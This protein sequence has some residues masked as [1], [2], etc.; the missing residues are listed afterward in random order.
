MSSVRRMFVAAGILSVCM[1][2]QGTP[3]ANADLL[4]PAA[5]YADSG[6]ESAYPATLTIDDVYGPSSPGNNMVVL[7]DSTLPD[8]PI[9]AYIV[10]DLGATCNVTAGTF[11]TRNNPSHM[12]SQP[13]SYQYFYYTDD[14]PANHSVLD[15]I[16]TDPGIVSL[17]NTGPSGSPWLDGGV[18]LTGTF[19]STVTAR[20]VGMRIDSSGPYDYTH[21]DSC[22][23]GEVKFTG[24]IIPEPGALIMC[25]VGLLGILAYAWRKRR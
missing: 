9:T 5:I 3:T 18:S 1:L 14:T 16:G 8:L 23:I 20:Y 7:T 2:W 10:F 13:D 12:N 24:T 25:G 19:T 15:A 21:T 11:W 6:T 17:Y 4:K 22:Q